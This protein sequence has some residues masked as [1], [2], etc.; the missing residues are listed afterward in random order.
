[1]WGAKKAIPET[2]TESET[3][4]ENESV[5]ENKKVLSA[6]KCYQPHKSTHKPAVLHLNISKVAS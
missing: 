3:E 2:E 5:N 4:S 6:K 1:M